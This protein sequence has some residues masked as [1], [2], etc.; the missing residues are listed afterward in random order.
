MKVNIEIEDDSKFLEALAEQ[1][2]HQTLNDTAEKKDADTY[3]LERAGAKG[4]SCVAISC[5]GVVA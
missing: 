3:Q 2:K 1:M 5:N 4:F